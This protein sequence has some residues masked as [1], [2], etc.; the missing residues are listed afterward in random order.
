MKRLRSEP[1]TAV[2][3]EIAGLVLDAAYGGV[4]PLGCGASARWTVVDTRWLNALMS[5]VLPFLMCVLLGAVAVARYA[6]G[7][8]DRLTARFIDGRRVTVS[9]SIRPAGADRWERGSFVIEPGGWSWEP[10]RSR[11]GGTALPADARIVRI[12]RPEGR[13]RNRLHYRL[14]VL[15][16][17]SADGDVRLA[18]EPGRLEHV[19]MKLA[20]AGY[21]VLRPPTG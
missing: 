6:N 5:N 3:V 20:P 21:E 13:E 15:E 4:L 11:A 2:L 8:Q 10:R 12:R 17:T 14:L 9:C 1:V 7:R 19:V 16:C 18:A